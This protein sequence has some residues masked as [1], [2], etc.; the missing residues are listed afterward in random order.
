MLEVTPILGPMAGAALAIRGIHARGV[1][2]DPGFP[3]AGFGR[4]HLPDFDDLARASLA[5]V[6]ARSHRLRSPLNPYPWVTEM[7]R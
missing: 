5:L 3:G 4:F 7:P 2:P 6:P 1:K